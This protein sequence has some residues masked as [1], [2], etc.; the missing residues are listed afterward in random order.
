MSYFE[1]TIKTFLATMFCLYLKDFIIDKEK[2][3]IRDRKMGFIDHIKYII[4][5]KGRNNDIEGVEFF[6]VFLKKKYETISRQAIG[7]QRAFIKPELF[8]MLYKRFIDFLYKEH[9]H[10]SEFKGYIVAACDGSIFDLPNVT[11]TRREFGIKD[12]TIFKKDRIRARVSGIL[13]VN[14]KFMLTTKIIEKTVKETTLAMEHLDDLKKRFNIEKF[15]TIYDRGYKSIELMLYTEKLNSKFIIRLPKNAF[16]KQIKRVKG[17]DK[18]IE[19]NLTN[20]VIKEFEKESTKK[21][22][23]EMGRYYARVVEFRLENGTK[24][25]LITNLDSEEFTMDDLK[26]LYGQRWSIETGFKKLKSQI[27]IEEFSGHRRIIIEQDFYASIF[28]YNLATAIQWDGEK[29]MSIQKR[30]PFKEYI[31]KSNF[32]SIVGLIYIYM[33]DILSNDSGIVDQVITFLI[34]QAKRLYHQKNI[35]DL[36]MMKMEKIVEDLILQMLWGDEWEKKKPARS[37]KDPSN[38]HPGTPKHTH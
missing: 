23:R 38:N 34:T 19:I 17:N 15:I 25:L 18:I 36:I 2:H 4:W 11:L 8:I 30:K 12:D 37:A 26:E 1:K 3:F 24:E 31:Y 28:I 32:A 20:S 13:D 16:S 10:F 9:K 14:S 27:Q 35:M 21:F 5:N 22:A 7:K 33:D 6:K 29:H